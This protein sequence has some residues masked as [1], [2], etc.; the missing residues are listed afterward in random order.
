MSNGFTEGA[1]TVLRALDGLALRHRITASNLANQSVP[2][3]RRREVS[4]E[5]QLERAVDG[6]RFDPKVTTDDESPAN[7]D[8]N[9]VDPAREVGVLTRIDLTYQA[10]SR[11]M[12]AKVSMMRSAITGR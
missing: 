11:A 7:A 9:N 10:L 4:F 8:G 5:D 6:G 2:G 1:Q 12:N 3:Y